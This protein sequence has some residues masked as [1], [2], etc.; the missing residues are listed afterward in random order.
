MSDKVERFMALLGSVWGKRHESEAAEA[1]WL[2][3]WATL[4]KPFEPWVL[5]A[6]AQRIME[7]RKDRYFPQPAEVR[8]IL[9]AIRAQDE[10]G[11]P[12]MRVSHEQQ[13]GDPF[14]L[15]DALVNCELGREAA[16]AEPCWV[17]ALHDFCRENR[18]LPNG[19][20][21]AKCKRVAAEFE[22]RYSECVRGAAGPNSK[23]LTKFAEGLIRKREAIRSK[24]I[25]RAAA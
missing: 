23:I 11:K 21:I 25:G 3:A 16:R 5:E 10:R 24:L 8:E 15:A 14:A 6:G 2:R 1:D 22:E 17:L 13:L 19:Q 9:V 7:T 20:E 12:Q 4:L 18:R